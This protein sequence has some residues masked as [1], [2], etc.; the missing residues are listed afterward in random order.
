MQWSK[1]HRGG[2]NVKKYKNY[3]WDSNYYQSYSGGTDYIIIIMQIHIVHT[4]D[5]SSS[6]I[7]V[8]YLKLKKTCNLCQISFES[9]G[10]NYSS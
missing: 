3:C 10:H 8:L 5:T 2:S 6:W 9:P 7:Y 4:D 1:K